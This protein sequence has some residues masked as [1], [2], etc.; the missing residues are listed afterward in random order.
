MLGFVKKRISLKIALSLICILAA[1]KG[2]FTFWLV[3]HLSRDIET[4]LFKKA[5][6]LVLVGARTMERILEEALHEGKFTEEQ[7]FDQNYRLIT[8][9]PLSESSI[10]KYHTDYDAYLDDKIREIQDAFTES[11]SAIVF[12]VLVDTNGYLP[13]HNSRYSK[14][15]TGNPAT[16]RIG[17]RTKRIFNDP[18]GI[19]AAHFKGT[20]EQPVLRQIYKRDTDET[21]WD[22]SAP[23]LVNG[24]HWGGFRIGLS[25]QETEEAIADLRNTIGLG[26]TGLLAVASLTIVIIVKRRIRPLE[27]V[28][29]SA[30]HIATGH[31]G[32]NIA[33]ESADEIGTLVN[34][35]NKM[36]CQLQ[37]T[38]I[39]RDYFDQIVES[40]QE[41]LL[42]LSPSGVIISA[43]RSACRL[44]GYHETE[45]VGSPALRLL[46]SNAPR[47]A[48][49]DID[50][51]R[52]PKHLT[53]FNEQPNP[54]FIAQNGREIPVTLSSSPIL[55]DN[56]EISALVWVAQDIT[57][58]LRME[59]DLKKSLANA[60]R[61]AADLEQ[62]NT[63]IAA[64]N[65][66]L[67][68]AYN[69]LTASQSII[70]Q[71]EKMASIG[72]LAAGV[73]HEINNPIGF[74]S[75]NL[76]SLGKYFEKL[77]IFFEIQNR[78]CGGLSEAVIK[79]E[80]DALRKKIKLDFLLQD[81]RDLIKESLEGTERVRKIVQGLKT[82]SRADQ[83]DRAMA[84]LNECLESTIHIAWNEIKYKATLH[85]DYGTL[86]ATL[87][88]PQKLNQVF[89][90]LLV[91]AAQAI[92][93]QG[94]ITVKTRY[95]AGRIRVWV[96]DTGCGIRQEHLKKV[97]EPF[98]T[99]KEVGKGTGLGMSIAYDIIKQHEGTISIDSEEGKGTTFLID[100]P[101]VEQ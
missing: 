70:L 59:L 30:E 68:K 57:E 3:E 14:P 15:L 76:N 93:K 46:G 89:M 48:V 98:F 65:T 84:D 52:D 85:R 61:M 78:A 4:L 50:Q 64:N 23:V 43:N 53:F 21:M 28:T 67:E 71:Q 35:F 97:F 39:S 17:N 32:K 94:D 34:A 10:P 16:D 5:G 80:L 99:T 54:T 73:A 12:A 36:T 81:G 95:E 69:E 86:P 42:T 29:R 77:A 100:L 11:D 82:F 37:Q 66:A 47:K 33:F 31:R 1:I 55:D 92:E 44:L 101:H 56:H 41:A 6:S 91:N 87:C 72:H 9:G 88:S 18:V 13:T 40:M 58:R 74:I 25:M 7:I 8:D 63:Q 62:Q 27:Q 45:L 22:V 26:M 60:Q 83:P 79:D 38:M 51:F 2:A 20:P 96:A 75:S 90:N 19:A 49:F 24:R